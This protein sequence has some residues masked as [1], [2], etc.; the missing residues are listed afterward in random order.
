MMHVSSGPSLLSAATGGPPLTP[1]RGPP[2]SL[3]PPSLRS[4]RGLTLHS[5]GRR[6]AG[7]EGDVAVVLEDQQ[8]AQDGQ[9][10]HPPYQALKIRAPA[11]GFQAPRRGRLRH[12]APYTAGEGGGFSG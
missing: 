8:D 3:T 7:E 9:G 5:A 4:S 10:D 6:V 11:L 2:S 12:T 1:L